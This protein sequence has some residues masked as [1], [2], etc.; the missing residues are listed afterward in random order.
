LIRTIGFKSVF[1]AISG[2]LIDRGFRDIAAP[3]LLNHPST[4]EEYKNL[5]KMIEEY[6]NN[7]ENL[8]AMTKVGGEFRQRQAHGTSSNLRYEMQ[9][10]IAL[11]NK[12]QT[13]DGAIYDNKIGK[14]DELET[15]R[16]LGIEGIRFYRKNL[17]Q[18]FVILFESQMPNAE[19][20]PI[21]EYVKL[22]NYLSPFTAYPINY[23]TEL[24]ISRFFGRLYE[25]VYLIDSKDMI[26]LLERANLI[27]EHFPEFSSIYIYSRA[28]VE[29]AIRELILYWNIACARFEAIYYLL[30]ELGY[31][32]EKSCFH[33]ANDGAVFQIIDLKTDKKLLGEADLEKLEASN[34]NNGF[35]EFD[36][37]QFMRPVLLEHLGSGWRK[38]LVPIETVISRI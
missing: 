18:D 32:P 10:G 14:I 25:D 16:D 7:M 33:L 17:L 21:I 35:Y 15:L 26:L 22:D 37:T 28:N 3:A 30:G 13:H 31:D 38:E 29:A 24:I 4:I 1:S 6:F 20:K 8:E 19:G 9:K 12:F 5:L 11:L 2:H 23:P 36:Q 34:L 27:F